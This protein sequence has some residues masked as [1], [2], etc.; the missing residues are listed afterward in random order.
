MGIEISRIG[1]VVIAGGAAAAALAMLPVGGSEGMVARMAAGCSQQTG[2]PVCAD[3]PLVLTRIGDLN[4]L[5][6]G[7]ADEFEV[8]GFSGARTT[9]RGYEFPIAQIMRSREGVPAAEPA[10]GACSV[11]TDP[12][13]A[14]RDVACTVSATETEFSFAYAVL[15]E[16]DVTRWQRRR[17]TY[18]MGD[19][20]G[21]VMRAARGSPGTI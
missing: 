18:S 10:Q 8:T 20:I 19:F 1:W 7:G 2:L 9:A 13:G 21:D 15:G 6:V 14:V 4:G 12:D 16:P 3:R 5:K 17:E 11:G